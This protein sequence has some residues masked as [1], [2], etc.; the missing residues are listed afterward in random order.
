MVLWI[1][2]AMDASSL[3][4]FLTTESLPWASGVVDGQGRNRRA[5]Q[6]G[7]LHH[8]LR[9]RGVEFDGGTPTN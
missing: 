2:A 7:D 5:I 9:Q 1:H 3:R 8:A 6:V 4:A